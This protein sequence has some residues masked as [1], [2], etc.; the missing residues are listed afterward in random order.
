M[1]M[2]E[3][4]LA[5]FRKPVLWLQIS[6][7]GLS[8]IDSNKISL[9]RARKALYIYRVVSKWLTVADAQKRK[10]ENKHTTKH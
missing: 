7:F 2:A 6:S 10:I 8:K 1:I 9:E 5:A 3:I 4:L